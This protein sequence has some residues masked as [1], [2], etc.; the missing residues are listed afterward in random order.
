MSPQIRQ[1]LPQINDSNPSKVSVYLTCSLEHNS[2]R[3]SPSCCW[4]GEQMACF[5]RNIIGVLIGLVSSF[6]HFDEWRCALK[7]AASEKFKTALLLS[8]QNVFSEWFISHQGALLRN[9][10]LT[11]K[12]YITVWRLCPW[13]LNVKWILLPCASSWF[14]YEQ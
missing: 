9:M 2:H 1:S 5:P 10:K 12:E 8:L 14:S 4:S 7:L 11:L 3:L 6:Y 13:M